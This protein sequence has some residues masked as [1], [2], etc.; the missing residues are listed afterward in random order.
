MAYYS[1]TKGSSV[2]NPP[3]LLMGAF[4]GQRG[5]SLMST[6]AAGQH[7]QGGN[8]WFYSSTNPV[9]TVCGANFFTDG[10][11]LG[12]QPGDVVIGN[13]FTSAGSSVVPFMHCVES[14]STSGATLSTGAA[15]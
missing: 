11:K 3:R 13:Y 7:Q 14:V 1:S 4:T 9:A 15:K 10:K 8:L 12:M 2:S 5:S 6:A